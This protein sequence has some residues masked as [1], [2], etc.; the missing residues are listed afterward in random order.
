[1]G[2]YKVAINDGP[3]CPNCA[4]TGFDDWWHSRTIKPASWPA[5]LQGSLQCH[6]CGRFFS[7]TQYSDGKCHSSM[8]GRVRKRAA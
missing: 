3:E 4:E 6:G 5:R 8:G 7:V 2:E 1:M